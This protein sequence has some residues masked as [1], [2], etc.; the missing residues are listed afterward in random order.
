LALYRQHK[1]N[2]KTVKELVERHWKLAVITLDE[3]KH[4]NK[5]A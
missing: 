5:T 3:D 1:L 4:L 2:E